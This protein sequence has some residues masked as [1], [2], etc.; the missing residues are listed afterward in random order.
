MATLRT[1]FAA[2][3][4][5]PTAGLSSLEFALLNALKEN[6]ELLIGSRN[7]P[8]GASRALTKADIGV[9]TVPT[10]NLRRVTAE[11]I[12][13]TISGVEV[14]SL[15]DFGKLVVNVQ[16]L[17]NDVAALNQTLQTL[18]QNLRS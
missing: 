15:E 11:G 2:V 10:Q 8:D 13:F 1:R 4:G 7:E 16:T 5:V 14:A 9:T 6:V 12:G 17:A 18:V 3:P